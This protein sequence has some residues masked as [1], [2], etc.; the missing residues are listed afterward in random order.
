MGQA[1]DVLRECSGKSKEYPLVFHGWASHGCMAAL[2][3]PLQAHHMVGWTAVISFGSGS[4]FSSSQGHGVFPRGLF[5][6]SFSPFLATELGKA[7][8]HQTR[9]LEDTWHRQDGVWSQG[10]S[11]TS[12][13]S[14]GVTSNNPWQCPCNAY[15]HAF[16][17][18]GPS[19][20]LYWN[21]LFGWKW[22]MF[23]MT[24]ADTAI[25]LSWINYKCL[26]ER[27]GLFDV[28]S[29]LLFSYLYVV[30]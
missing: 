27:K 9:L 5:C 11:F 29:I 2:S 19:N 13:T 3:F 30:V 26:G 17:I 10:P 28:F 8:H 14:F 12:R 1:A 24:L 23:S 4:S 20:Y 22:S 16:T 15:F 25:L 18:G 6:P 21:S 7:A